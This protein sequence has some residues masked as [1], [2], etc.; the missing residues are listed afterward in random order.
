MMAVDILP[1]SLP[2][3]ASTHFSSVLQ[4]YLSALVREYKGM[5]PRDDDEARLRAALARATIAQG[6]KLASGSDLT[7]QQCR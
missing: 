3:D 1:T 7:L 6:G 5:E 4:P 2:L